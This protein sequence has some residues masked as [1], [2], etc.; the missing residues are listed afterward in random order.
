MIRL[1]CAL[2]AAAACVLLGFDAARRLRVRVKLLE[3]WIRSLEWID[4]KLTSEG[5]PLREVVLKEGEG[6]ISQRLAAFSRALQGN[7]RLSAAQA[8][9]S[10]GKDQNAPEDAVL[11]QCFSALGTGFLEKRRTALGQAVSQLRAMHKEAEEKAERD[12][13]LYKSMGLAGGAA[14]LLLLL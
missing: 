3:A 1:A 7:P 13:R 4:M 5:I 8:W 11:A 9:A 12:C 2:M 14:L 6:E 10:S